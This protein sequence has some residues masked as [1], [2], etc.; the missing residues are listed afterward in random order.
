MRSHPRGWFENG[1]YVWGAEISRCLTCEVRTAVLGEREFLLKERKP[2]PLW[3][4]WMAIVA[5]VLATLGTALFTLRRFHRW[6]F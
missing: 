5:G 2:S 6:P 1:L 3:L 4:G